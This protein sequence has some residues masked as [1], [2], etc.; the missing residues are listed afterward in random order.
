MSSA[1]VETV[2]VHVDDIVSVC[3]QPPLPIPTI[4]HNQNTYFNEECVICFDSIKSIQ[5]E[6]QEVVSFE[7][8]HLICRSCVVEYLKNQLKN[9]LD[10]TCPM[11]RF[12]LL[13]SHSASYQQYRL[14]LYSTINTQPNDD[15]TISVEERQQQ[16]QEHIAM[17]MH[18]YRERRQQQ[19]NRHVSV[20]RRRTL[21]R[22]LVSTPC[23]VL[24]LIVCTIVGLYTTGAFK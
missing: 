17:Q 11:C 6:G 18:Y 22:I 10:I 15:V 8:Q 23:L 12:M 7:C 16:M 20:Y 3:L 4:T 5:E 1:N 14:T 19:I 13:N 24:M 21:K 9:G 2:V